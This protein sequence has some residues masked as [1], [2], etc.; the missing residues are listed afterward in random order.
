MT[1]LLQAVHD[2]PGEGIVDVFD[3]D[4]MHVATIYP[5]N[6]S[7]N[8]IQI[9]SAYIVSSYVSETSPVAD[10]PNLLLYFRKTS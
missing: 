6:D 10:V 1:V 3:D 8:T 2:R 7:S 4:G 9:V 5:T